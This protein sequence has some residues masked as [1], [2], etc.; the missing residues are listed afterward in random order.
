MIGSPSKPNDPSKTQNC[1]LCSSLATLQEIT[2]D[3]KGQV[4][5]KSKPIVCISFQLVLESNGIPRIKRRH[6][7]FESSDVA[8]P[9]SSAYDI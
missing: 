2:V 7:N 9:I 1:N 8:E 3:K 6:C 4:V 5:A